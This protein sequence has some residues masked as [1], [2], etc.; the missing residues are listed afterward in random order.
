MTKQEINN[1]A[2]TLCGSEVAHLERHYNLSDSEM[3]HRCITEEK[4][5]VT[6][7]TIDEDEIVKQIKGM[8]LDEYNQAEIIDWLNDESDG[9]PWA[10]EGEMDAPVGRGFF[11]EHWH[12][13]NAGAANCSLVVL[14]LKKVER[15]Y[16]TTF[17]IAS[18]YPSYSE[19][20]K[21]ELCRRQAEYYSQKA[22]EM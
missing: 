5:L 14:V 13:W 19:K 8:L 21:E 4:N 7:F 22:E 2:E 10:L 16:D 15:R 1:F 17:R 12:E 18:C 3:I 11:K 6:T 9:E 20:D